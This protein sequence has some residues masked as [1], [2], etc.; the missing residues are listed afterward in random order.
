MPANG[1]LPFVL[2]L[3]KHGRADAADPWGLLLL[4]C[5]LRE[6]TAT[7]DVNSRFREN[8]GLRQFWLTSDRDGESNRWVPAF[9]GMTVWA[10]GDA[11]ARLGLRPAANRHC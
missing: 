5:C 11:S 6:Q 9:A 8:D 10:A 4:V 2:R 3:S 7:C 1:S